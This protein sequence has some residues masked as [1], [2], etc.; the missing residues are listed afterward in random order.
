M[1]DEKYTGGKCTNLIGTL[2]KNFCES[3]EKSLMI[4]TTHFRLKSENDLNRK[5][6]MLRW[7]F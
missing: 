6:I 5:E 7:N 1:L 3:S 4:S 2:Y